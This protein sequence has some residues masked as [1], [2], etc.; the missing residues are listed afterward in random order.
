MEEVPDFFKQV[1]LMLET[2]NS[3]SFVFAPVS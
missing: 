2:S 3:G 1:I